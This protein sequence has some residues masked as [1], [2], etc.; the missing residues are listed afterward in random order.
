MFAQVQRGARHRLPDPRRPRGPDR[1]PTRPTTSP[2]CA[3]RCRWRSAYERAKGQDDEAH[4][5]L[6]AAWRRD[7]SDTPEALRARLIELDVEDAAAACSSP[8]RRR[9]SARCAVLES[10]SLKGL[11]RRVVGKIFNDIELKGWCSEFEARNAAGRAAGAEA[12]AVTSADLVGGFFREQLTIRRRVHATAPAHRDL[13]YTVFGL[14]GLAA[15]RAPIA[16]GPHRAPTSPAFG[17]GAALDFVHLSCLARCWANLP[18]GVPPAD[19][20]AA[21]ARSHRHVPRRRRR[22]RDRSGRRRGIRLRRASSRLAPTRIC[23]SRCPTAT[24]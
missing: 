5:A 15:L 7:T 20:R 8:T 17:D 3:R 22:L 24:R 1:Q 11:L 18:E 16:R 6:V 23:A 10:P 9:R 13:Y 19:V 4:A 12:A 21:H 2:R 14:E